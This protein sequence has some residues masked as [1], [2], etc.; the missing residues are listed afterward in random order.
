MTFSIKVQGQ[1]VQIETKASARARRLSL[2]LVVDRFTLVIPPRTSAAQIKGFITQ[3]VPWIEKQHQNLQPVSQILP[4]HPLT[5]EGE[6]YACLLDPLRRKP[7]LCE[8]TRTLRLPPRYTRADLHVFF[9]KRA[10]EVFTPHVK[11]AA[12]ALG[13]EVGRLSFRDQRSRWGS[14]SAT[15]NISLSWRLLF[16]PPDV[17]AYVCIHEV[18]HIL[19]MNHSPS[20]WKVV[21]SLCPGYKIHRKWLKLNG[22]QLMRMV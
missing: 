18:S 2:R 17:A 11:K 21:E 12:L 1:E 13:C 6:S 16:A 14:C 10:A 22:Q 19:H 9:K 5:L 4:G 15:K 3:C 20:F 8:S 7:A